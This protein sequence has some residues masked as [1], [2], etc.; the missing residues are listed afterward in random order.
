MSQQGI[1]GY[2]QLTE[3]LKNN[4]LADINVLIQ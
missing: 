4:Y 1:R 3:T 2:Y